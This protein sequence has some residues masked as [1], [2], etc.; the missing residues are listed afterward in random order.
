MLLSVLVATLT[1]VFT[2]AIIVRVILGWF[3]NFQTLVPVR[4]MLNHATDPL[5]RP[6]QRRLPAFGGFDLS[7]IVAILL[8]SVSGSVALTLLAG[9]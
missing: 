5:L 3:P 6:I 8:I 4:A 9:Q 7:P 1:Q 2:L